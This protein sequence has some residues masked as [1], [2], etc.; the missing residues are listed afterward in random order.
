LQITFS[1]ILLVVCRV[2]IVCRSHINACKTYRA[3]I[4]LPPYIG[5]L[6]AYTPICSAWKT[7]TNVPYHLHRGGRRFES[8]S[9][10]LF[11]PTSGGF[12]LIWARYRGQAL[13]RS[14][15]GADRVRLGAV[16]QFLQASILLLKLFKTVCLI[17]PHTSILFL[18]AVVGLY[19][20]PHCPANCSDS[21]PL[22]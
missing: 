2:Q 13:R 16:L 6:D 4:V 1:R 17:G 22:A 19:A 14:K 20:D 18:T 15:S 12:S 11:T 9:A 3:W 8:Y 5:L 21:L 7:W 10:H